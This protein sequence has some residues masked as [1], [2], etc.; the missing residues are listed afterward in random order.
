MDGEIPGEIQRGHPERQQAPG[1]QAQNAPQ[2][3]TQA[4][5][6]ESPNAPFRVNR[7]EGEL[8][9][10]RVGA[11]VPSHAETRVL[12][13]PQSSMLAVV[14][15]GEVTLDAASEEFFQARLGILARLG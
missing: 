3:S 4:S 10:E 9:D 15:I 2:S 1:Q 7:K 11:M 12:G 14:A 6:V 5:P 13:I 8:S